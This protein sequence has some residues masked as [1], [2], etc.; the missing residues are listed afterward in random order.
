MILFNYKFQLQVLSSGFIRFGIEDSGLDRDTLGLLKK[1]VYDI[2]GST[3]NIAHQNV[4][5]LKCIQVI[6]AIVSRTMRL[7]TDIIRTGK[8]TR[9]VRSVSPESCY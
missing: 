6:Y 7:P 2:A 5:S 9:R 3:F 8:S 4:T 1:R